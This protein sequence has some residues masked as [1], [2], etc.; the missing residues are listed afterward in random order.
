MKKAYILMSKRILRSGGWVLVS[1]S[2]INIYYQNLVNIFDV[3]S[4]QSLNQDLLN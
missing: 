1:V 3:V 4:R 2:D